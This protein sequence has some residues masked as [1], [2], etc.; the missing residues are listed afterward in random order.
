MLMLM[1]KDKSFK[2]YF[3]IALVISAIAAIFNWKL[4]LGFALGTIVSYLNLFL[5][6]KKF[7]TL[8]G[9]KKT[10]SIALTVI[11]IQGLLTIALALATY[12]IAGL[13]CF[14]AGFAGMIIPNFV[15]IIMGSIKK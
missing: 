9:K 5:N 10:I 14:L 11:V 7:P 6:E 2:V 4:G 13:S 3:I 12:F 8:D 15:F 1:L